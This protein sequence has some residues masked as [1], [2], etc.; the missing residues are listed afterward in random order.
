MFIVGS[1]T[2]LQK[3][4]YAYYR[5]KQMSYVNGIENKDS[6]CYRKDVPI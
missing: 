6:Q 3:L 1:N 2:L 5:I 4:F